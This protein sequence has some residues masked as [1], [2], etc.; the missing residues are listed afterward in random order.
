[1]KSFCSY[2]IQSSQP[3]L[4]ALSFLV[5][6][7]KAILRSTL[8]DAKTKPTESPIRYSRDQS[9]RI[10]ASITFAVIDNA[11]ILNT[12]N[13]LRRERIYFAA[14]ATRPRM[15]VK[16]LVPLV[17]STISIPVEFAAA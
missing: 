11:V 2:S 17:M 3:K 16:L 12:W 15:H 6:S 14:N 9:L 1:M 13:L 5:R 10:S 7:R 4:G 8:K